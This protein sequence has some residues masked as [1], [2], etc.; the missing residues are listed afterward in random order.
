MAGPARTIGDA[1]RHRGPHQAPARHPCPDRGRRHDPPCP[2]AGG[3]L[4]RREPS[5]AATHHH[6]L[7]GH[8]YGAHPD[9]DDRSRRPRNSR[10]TVPAVRTFDAGAH[11]ADLQDRR[12]LPVPVGERLESLGVG[13]LRWQRHRHQFGLGVRHDGPRLRP[14]L[15]GRR[16]PCRDRRDVADTDRVLRYQRAG[17]ATP[18]SPDD[19]RRRGRP[20]DRVLRR[21]D[22]RAR[23]LPVPA[24]GARCD[25]G[26]GVVALA[27]RLRPVRPRDVREHVLRPDHALPEQPE[28]RRLA[29]HRQCARIIPGRRDRRDHSGGRPR[30]C[31]PPIPCRGRAATGRRG[32]R[33]WCRLGGQPWRAV[34]GHRRCHR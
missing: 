20:G 13:D 30:V 11:R 21:S 24:R 2:L 19:A 29:G 14:G 10:R 16:D 28:H 18:G 7:G 33:E 5:D 1:D 3:W 15:L 4:R 9:R 12:R 6:A 32:G 25:P 23:A 34:A 8:R 27:D 26:R 17:G 22:P 31:V